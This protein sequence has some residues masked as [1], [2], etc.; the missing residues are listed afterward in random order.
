MSCSKSLVSV[1]PY[2]VYCRN[3]LLTHPR[4]KLVTMTSCPL[5]KDPIHP[6]NKTEPLGSKPQYKGSDHSNNDRSHV[7]VKIKDCEYMDESY[8]KD[9]ENAEDSE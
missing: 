5:Q 8:N 3:N 7:E 4:K 2:K 9:K 6:R 1:T